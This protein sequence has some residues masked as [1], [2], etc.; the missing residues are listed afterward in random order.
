MLVFYEQE[1]S[2]TTSL[3]PFDKLLK[4]LVIIAGL[5]YLGLCIVFVLKYSEDCEVFVTSFII[6]SVGQLVVLLKEKVC[7]EK[8]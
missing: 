5:S 2:T 7:K 1:R 8:N 6:A 4:S 3:E